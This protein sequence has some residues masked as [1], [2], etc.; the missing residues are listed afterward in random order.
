MKLRSSGK[1][2]FVCEQKKNKYIVLDIISNC[3]K[4]GEFEKS[5]MVPG[6]ENAA[7]GT[8]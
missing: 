3:F 8:N 7:F 5:M 1:S 6:K 4:Y 2:N